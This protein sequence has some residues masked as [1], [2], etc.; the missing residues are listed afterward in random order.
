M[1]KLTMFLFLLLNITM[2]VLAQ[3]SNKE[4]F[5]SL[6]SFGESKNTQFVNYIESGNIKTISI[7][8]E[9]LT[10]KTVNTMFVN[11]YDNGKAIVLMGAKLEFLQFSNGY[12]IYII[13]NNKVADDFFNHQKDLTITF[14]NFSEKTE[15]EFDFKIE[16]SES[17][18]LKML[19]LLYKENK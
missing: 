1:K 11:A 16:V 13:G 2:S 14:Y 10:H 4:N 7:K 18:V 6:S 19:T 3:S 15:E 17:D 5:F 12:A 8:V 9:G